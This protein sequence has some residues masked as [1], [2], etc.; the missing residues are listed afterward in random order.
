MLE[1]LNYIKLFAMTVIGGVGGWIIEL[2][3]GWTEDLTTLLIFMGVDYFLGLLI[4]GFWKKSNKSE[5]GTLSSW[6]AW[7]GLCRKG[8]SLL[9]VLIAHRLDLTLSL[10]YIKTAVIIAF[11]A[12]EGLSIMEN[13]GIMGVPFSPV[14]QNAIEILIKRSEKRD[15]GE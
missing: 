15:E 5:T 13:L 2:F 7:K 6:S 9:V 3:G 1:K 8:V 12:N 11:I 4:A 10:S 14:I